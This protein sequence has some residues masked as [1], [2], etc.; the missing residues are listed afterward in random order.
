MW[1]WFVGEVWPNLFA[2]ALTT[3]PALAWHHRRMKR[4]IT[5]AVKEGTQ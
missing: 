1:G 3:M 2:S 5:Q 4:H